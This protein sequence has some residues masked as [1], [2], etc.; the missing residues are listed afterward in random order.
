MKEFSKA[1]D[2]LIRALKTFWQAVVAYLVTS[3]GTQIAGIEVFSF[4][5]LK[6][7]AIGLLVGAIAAGLSA[8]WNGVIQPALDKFKAEGG[9]STIEGE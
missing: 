6:N 5:A 1:K 2:I 8:A 7:V 9:D 4:D 3:F